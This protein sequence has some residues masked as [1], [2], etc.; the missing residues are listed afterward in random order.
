MRRYAHNQRSTAYELFARYQRFDASHAAHNYYTALLTQLGARKGQR[1]LH[2]G[3]ALGY[4]TAGAC[5]QVG[6]PGA[7]TA[8][9]DASTTISQAR[10]RHGFYRQKA[11]GWMIPAT[12]ANTECSGCQMKGDACVPQ[13]EAVQSFDSLPFADGS[14][15]CV[16]E[17]RV[18]QRH[19]RPSALALM[20]EL[21]R[22]TL[23]G[24]KVVLGMVDYGDACSGASQVVRPE[25]LPELFTSV[26]MRDIS[27]VAVPSPSEEEDVRIRLYT[28]SGTCV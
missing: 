20:L 13:W 3:A 19:D 10:E 28:C 6:R 8:I 7:V 4:A 15:D 23:P 18:V 21:A 5:Y 22:L 12:A 9:D 16:L 2:V 26:G 14:F 27:L 1:V 25:V 11:L 17:D 24:G